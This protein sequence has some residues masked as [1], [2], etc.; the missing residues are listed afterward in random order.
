VASEY[1]KNVDIHQEETNL[2][3]SLM[4]YHF[5]EGMAQEIPA[6]ARKETIN[7]ALALRRDL[8]YCTSKDGSVYVHPPV[9]LTSFSAQC[10]D[11]PEERSE[12]YDNKARSITHAYEGE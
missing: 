10:Q 8:V 12:A 7:L 3:Q 2:A 4:V 5:L 1:M 11:T 9:R 6:L